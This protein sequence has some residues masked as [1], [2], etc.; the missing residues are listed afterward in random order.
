MKILKIEWHR[1]VEDGQTCPRCGATGKEVEKASNSLQQSLAP[2]GIKVVLEK[3]EITPGAFQQDPSISNRILFNGIPLE[4]VLGLKVGQSPCC[5]T[6]GD[7]E[8][9]TLE[10]GGQVYE[11]IPTNLIIQAGLQEAAK[12]VSPQKS[13]PCCHQDAT[14][15]NPTPTCCPK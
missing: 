7:A 11:T 2:L 6:C 5:G 15:K 14:V 3:Y 4:E 13:D 1:L 8:C 10:T 9:R 12:L